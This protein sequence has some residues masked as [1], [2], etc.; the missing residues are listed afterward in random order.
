MKLDIFNIFNWSQSLN[1]SAKLLALDVSKFDKSKYSILHFSNILFIL[2][3]E[4]VLKLDKFILFKDC[5]NI[6]SFELPNFEE[7]KLQNIKNMFYG[8]I[9]LISV[10]LSNFNT[11]SVINMEYLFYNCHKLQ[12]LNLSNYNTNKVQNMEYMFFNCTSS[13]NINLSSFNTISVK[14][15]N[16]I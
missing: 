1:I 11:S 8:C 9:S 2:F 15:M 6:T 14:K 7:L 12:I 16:N 13:I 10:D 4:I 5:K 3:T